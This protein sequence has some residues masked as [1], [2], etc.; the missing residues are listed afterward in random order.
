MS[1][2]QKIPE[3]ESATSD[4]GAERSVSYD[5]FKKLLGEKKAV[6]EKARAAE[7]KAAELEARIA[8]QEEQKA[9]QNKE[10]E[11]LYQAEKAQRARAEERA[12]AEAA[13]HSSFVKKQLFIQAVGGLRK[14]EYLNFVDLDRVEIAENGEPVAES[15]Q[16]YVAEFQSKFPELVKEKQSKAGL[17]ASAPSNKG[18]PLSEDKEFIAA[19]MKRR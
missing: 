18:V 17:P 6:A 9:I 2:E 4:D 5:S 10:F 12:Q 19:I 13:K 11:K 8:A 16:A 3:G 1:D 7:Q 14:P 15:L